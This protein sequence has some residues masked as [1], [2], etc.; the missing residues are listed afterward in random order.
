MPIML[1]VNELEPGMYL[2]SNIVNQFSVIL[3]QGHKLSADDIRT[4]KERYKQLNIHVSDPILDE[5]AEFE[6]PRSATDTSPETRHRLSYLSQKVHGALKSKVTL[7]G[8]NIRGM[9]QT[10]TELVEYLEKHPE[11]MGLIEESL[12]WE[13]SLREHSAGVFYLSLVIGNTFRNIRKEKAAKEGTAKKEEIIPS[14]LATAAL[15]HD[16]GMVALEDLTNKET[17][18]TTDEFEIVKQHP[19]AGA[20]ILGDKID[21]GIRE[22]VRDHHENESGTGYPDGLKSDEIGSYAKIIRVTDAYTAGTSHRRYRQTKSSIRVL[23]EMLEGDYC[24]MYDP[25]SLRIL[26]KII[27]PIPAGAKLKLST[28]Q[29]AV[30]TK[31]NVNEPFGPQVII[32]F[33]ENNKPLPRNRLVGPFDLAARKDLQ[34]VSFGDE[35]LGYLY[36]ITDRSP[37]DQGSGADHH[38]QDEGINPAY[39]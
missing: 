25:E 35:D 6:E 8:D 27:R 13:N 33:D 22:A 10:I 32:A 38:N 2:A 11:A 39:P 36:S 14:E 9:Q 30:V 37:A 26:S 31:H 16:I 12:Q 15:L 1:S 29:H 21:D 7:E 28:N 20:N 18:L 24:K 19:A 5:S 3:P 17:S 4:L 34:L 23:H